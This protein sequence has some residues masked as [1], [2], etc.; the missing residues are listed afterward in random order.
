MK[1]K[2]NEIYYMPENTNV[3][4]EKFLR[5]LEDDEIGTK[6]KYDDNSYCPE[7]RK[8]KLRWS[9]GLKRSYFRSYS[10]HKEGCTYQSKKVGIVEK[11]KKTDIPSDEDIIAKLHELRNK[12]I[13]SLKSRADKSGVVDESAGKKR[14]DKQFLNVKT[15]RGG[16]GRICR[17]ENLSIN[18][19]GE[20]KLYYGICNCFL[21]DEDNERKYIHLYKLNTNEYIGKISVTKNVE[22]HLGSTIGRISKDP[23]KKITLVICIWGSPQGDNDSYRFV[24]RHSKYISIDIFD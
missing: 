6:K 21:T 24:L 23:R 15:K 1:K 8:A 14:K 5:E 7:C 19:I 4:I 17:I 22:K 9:N 16:G 11:Q 20:S 2:Y 12:L 18:N 13:F 10:E 3:S